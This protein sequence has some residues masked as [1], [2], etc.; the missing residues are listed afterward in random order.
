MVLSYWSTAI[1]EAGLIGKPVILL[2][3]YGIFSNFREFEKNKGFF[4]Y[5]FCRYVRDETELG[6]AIDQLY[7]EFRDGKQMET[8]IPPDVTE[9]YLGPFDG[10][11]T[12]RVVDALIQDRD[13]HPMGEAQRPIERS[14]GVTTPLNSNGL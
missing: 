4:D 1:Q 11:C 12:N 10:E 14:R 5:G 6:Q 9:Y 2:D 7:R 13:R 8:K 3:L